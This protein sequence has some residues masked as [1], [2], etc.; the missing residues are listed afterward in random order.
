MAMAQSFG[1]H[2]EW[3]RLREVVAEKW[4]QLAD[5]LSVPKCDSDEIGYPFPF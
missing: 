2:H 4:D 3:G 5:G 1:V